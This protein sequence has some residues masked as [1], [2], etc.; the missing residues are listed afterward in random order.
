MP[1]HR[2]SPP[3]EPSASSDSAPERD[4]LQP[5]ERVGHNH[6]RPT[7]S[8]RSSSAPG[9]SRVAPPVS[10]HTPVLDLD[11]SEAVRL[12]RAW[13]IAAVS[14]LVVAISAVAADR[15]HPAIGATFEAQE[16][17]P[18]TAI[19]L[20]DA[21]FVQPL[22]ATASA[23][24]LSQIRPVGPI[25]VPGRGGKLLFRLRVA[26][27]DCTQLVARV[28]GSC[29]GHP[30]PAPMPE[31]LGII[32]PSGELEARL[33]M[34]SAG[35][36]RLGQNREKVRPR[37]SREW[38]L[39]ENARETTLTLR[40]LRPVSL[41]VTRFPVHMHPS[42]SPD[43][44]FFEL[45]LVNH[46]PYAPILAFAG[47]RSFRAVTVAGDVEMTVDSG[48]LSFGDVQRRVH[49]VEPTTVALE[50]NDPI[51]MR[52]ASPASEWAAPTRLTSGETSSATVG[53]EDA[54][55]SLLARD[56]TAKSIVYGTIV[57]L[58]IGALTCYV[59]AL[60]ANLSREEQR[61]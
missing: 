55:P 47:S 35:K 60:M 24:G 6:E 40:C 8:A 49:G 41:T 2:R 16:T 58:L 4:A 38:S 11:S 52:L 53:G 33:E 32:A 44:R 25:E 42:C 5:D 61:R 29:A 10:E 39:N 59:R 54:V 45:A 23:F 37:P 22:T 30:Q 13:Q 9:A 14:F 26:A 28:G 50:G 15:L 36:A 19:T 3:S 57:T 7:S 31:Q 48:M 20:H 21:R 17:T 51:E 34:T 1:E 46:K 43:G 27:G 18:G 12:E 56:S